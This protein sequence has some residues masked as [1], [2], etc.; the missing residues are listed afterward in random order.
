MLHRILIVAATKEEADIF[1]T[2]RNFK[3]KPGGFLYHGIYISVLVTGVGSVP[4][5]WEMQKWMALNEKPELAINIGIAG[6]YNR[7]IRVGEV[8]LPVTDCFADSGIE[9]GNNFRTLFEAGLARDSDFPFING[10]IE[11]DQ[12]Y[13]ALLERI[14]RPVKAITVN[15]A[16][17]TD[18]TRD[19]LAEK[20][21]PDIETME[22]A[23]F[24]YICSMEGVPFIALRSV[25][26]MVEKRDRSKWNIQLALSNLAIK[27]EEIILT[28]G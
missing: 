9:D 12:K 18:N 27:L 5:S 4:T 24:F 8:V 16:T 25:S 11:A 15:T 23:T 2:I 7:D 19:R 28:L 1:G 3:K 22:G 26:N 10:V 20:F 14:A 21:N 17:G 13:C 6:S